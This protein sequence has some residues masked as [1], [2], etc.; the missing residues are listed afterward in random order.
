MPLIE[1]PYIFAL[2]G[3]VIFIGFFG[4]LL[5]AK[6]K[7]PDIVILIM[8]G[9]LIGPLLTWIRGGESLFASTILNGVAP[10]VAT[11]ALI[12]ILFD[13]GLGLNFDKV[14]GVSKISMI[15]AITGFLFAMLFSAIIVFYFFGRDIIL[16]LILGAI[17][18]GSSAAIV[19]PQISGMRVSEE[20]KTILILESVLTDVL[21]VVV[22]FSLIEIEIG[23]GYISPWQS[24]AGAFAIGIVIALIFGILWLYVLKSLQGKPYSFMITI[25]ALLVLYGLVEFLGGSGVI[26][27]LIFGFVLSNRSEITRMFKMKT[28]FIF[29]EKIKQFQS[30]LSFF[31]TTFFFVYLGMIFIIPPPNSRTFW[32]FIIVSVL[33]YLVIQ[34]CRFAASWYIVKLQPKRKRELGIFTMM[35]PRG[36]TTAVLASITITKLSGVLA[37]N[38]L[39]ELFAS[40]AFMVILLTCIT[41]TVGTF[42]VERKISI[43]K[44]R[45]K[46]RRK[47][48]KEMKS[49]KLKKKAIH[50]RP[51]KIE[52]PE[53]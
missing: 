13:G 42:I 49:E 45:K 33:I 5:F 8:L 35:G 46:K 15:L 39:L 43:K 19:I 38:P 30:E 17:V 14:I 9:V 2:A 12:I 50:K 25:A 40:F 3:L 10:Y 37:T 31:V 28:V 4:A 51:A 41:T 6:T 34:V 32:L 48:N 22:V 36:L 7:I 21:S 18:G 26:A 44:A 52:T 1:V 16:S 20:T 23:S 53:F 29:D 47:R 11:L 24:L 27:A